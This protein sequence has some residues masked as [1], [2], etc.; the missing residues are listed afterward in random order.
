MRNYYNRNR[1][2]GYIMKPINLCFKDSPDPE[3]I[4]KA[5][6]MGYRAGYEDGKRN[7]LDASRTNYDEKDIQN[8]PI[9]ALPISFHAQASLTHS[10]CRYVSEVAKLP[11]DKIKSLRNVGKVTA[12]EIAQALKE[13]GITDTEWDYAWLID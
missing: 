4:R 5:Y 12:R 3:G 10:G 11:A 8:I 1:K 13:F 7:S 2:R 6:I 9:E